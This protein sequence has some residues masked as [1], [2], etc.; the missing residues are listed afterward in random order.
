[1][2]NLPIERNYPSISYIL[3]NWP[4]TKH[5]LR[6]YVLSNFKKP[7]L[8]DLTKICLKELK[9]FKIKGCQP[10]LKKLSKICSSN[11][12][13]NTYHD[14]HHFKAVLVI[15]ALL[16]MGVNLKNKDRLLLIVISLTHDMNH[17]GRRIINAIPYY[18][19]ERSFLDLQRIF[20]RKV[21]N[22]KE[23][24]RIRTIFKSTYFPIKP[25]NVK[26]DLEK[27]VLDADI[28]TSLMFGP[29]AGV[30]L[31]GRLKHEIKY[32]D[33]TEILFRNFLKLLG[34]KCLYLPFSKKL[35]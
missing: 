27:I 19:E 18:Q 5:I 7:D 30:K 20:F 12:T 13:S 23:I 8:Y 6:K 26:D 32:N 14:Q 21:L 17:Q 31:A 34:E 2:R 28:L 29:R 9:I 10:V 35:C 24:N 22:F 16:A 1:M 3:N 25:K 11:V 4:K 33:E 15:S